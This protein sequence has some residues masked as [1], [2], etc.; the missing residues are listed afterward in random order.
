[1]NLWNGYDAERIPQEV[2]PPCDGDKSNTNV[3]PN[4]TEPDADPDTNEPNEAGFGNAVPDTNA[5]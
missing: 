2:P 3:E 4:E 5:K 1:M